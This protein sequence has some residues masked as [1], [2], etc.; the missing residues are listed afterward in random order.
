MVIFQEKWLKNLLYLLCIFFC[1]CVCVFVLFGF[2]G[3]GGMCGLYIIQWINC[4]DVIC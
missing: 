2:V 3:G 4:I 1:M